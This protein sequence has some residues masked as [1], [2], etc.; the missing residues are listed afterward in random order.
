MPKEEELMSQNEWVKV[1]PDV[2]IVSDV[3]SKYHRFDK[4]GRPVQYLNL[5][6]Q[7]DKSMDEDFDN[8]FYHVEKFPS[9]LQKQK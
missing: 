6:K 2:D 9:C 5:I 1:Q 8:I 3:Q 7:S 4:C